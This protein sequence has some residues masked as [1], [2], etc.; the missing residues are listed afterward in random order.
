MYTTWFRIYVVG[1]VS[2][3]RQ[4][5][6]PVRGWA[7]CLCLVR[8][9]SRSDI[10]DCFDTSRSRGVRMWWVCLFVCP[11]VCL[12]ARITRKLH[13]RTSSKFFCLGPPLAALRYVVYFRFCGWCHVFILRGQWAKIKHATFIWSSPG[14]GIRTQLDVK[15]P[16][17]F[18]GVHQN[19]AL[20]SGKNDRL[21][22]ILPCSTLTFSQTATSNKS[23]K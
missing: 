11:S 6:A 21:K 10:H 12:S 13:S 3:I 9:P 4:V 5:A 23:S 7:A 15:T 17:V 20:A 14:C 1:Y 8:S 22:V 2:P 19:V 16:T 18:G